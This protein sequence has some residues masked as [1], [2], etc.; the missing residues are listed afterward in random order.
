MCLAASAH[1]VELHKHWSSTQCL[2]TYL[3]PDGITMHVVV[4]LHGTVVDGGYRGRTNGNYGTD[5]YHEWNITVSGGTVAQPAPVNLFDVQNFAVPGP[6]SWS[7]VPEGAPASF[8]GIQ[9]MTTPTDVS[10]GNPVDVCDDVAGQNFDETVYWDIYGPD[11]LFEV[12]YTKP[13]DKKLGGD[14]CQGSPPMALY[15]AHAE[16][17]SLNIQDTPFRYA[18]GRGPSINFTVT[19]NQRDGQPA[20]FT[21]SNLGPKWAFNWLS[22][23]TD[24]PNDD[25]AN[26]TTYVPGG[27]TEVYSG[28]N[29]MTQSYSPDPQSH[30]VLVRTSSSSYEK[31]FPDGSKQIFSVTDGAATYPRKIF[32]TQFIDPAGNAATIGYDGSF[33]VT[34]ITDALGYVTN[35]SYDLPDD[36]LKITKV[37]EP[38]AFGLNRSA[39]FSYTNGQLTTITDEIGIQSVFAYDP[40]SDFIN[41]LTTPY[42]T[43][44][45][46]TGENGTNRWVEMTDPLGAT[47]RVEYRDNAPGISDSDPAGTVPTGFT[48]SGLATG[49]TFYWDKKAYAYYPD[50]TKARITHWALNSDGSPSGI[51]ASEKAPLENRIWYAYE[52]QSDTNHAGPS[53]SPN[54]VARILDDG[55]TQLRQYEYNAIG[56]VTKA[57]DPIGRVTSYQYDANN[58]DLLAVY[59]ER[60]GG[61]SVDPFNAA[62]DL[63]ASYANYY[64]HKPQAVTD[65]A[66]QT[67]NYVY[68]SYG[69][70]QSV[71]NPRNE[72]T[73][74]GY[75]D[76]SS[77]HPSG[78]LTSITSPT[79]NSTSAVTT[80]DYDTAN[81]VR[82]VTS[83]PDGYATVSDYDNLDRPVQIAYPD[84][85]TRQF[86]Y[87]QDFGSGLKTILDLTASKDRDGRWTYRH[88]NGNRQMDSITDPLGQTTYYDWCS[89]GS[90]AG[91]V[92]PN[93]SGVNDLAHKTVFNRDLQSRVTSKVFADGSAIVYTYENTTSRLKSMTDANGQTTNYE[94][95]TD[96]DLAQVSYTNALN[97]TPTVGYAYDPYYNRITSM[98]DGLGTTSYGY[99]PVSTSPTLGAGKL[100]TVDGPFA[101]DTITYG[102]DELG[103]VVSQDINGTAA[104]VVYDSLGRPGTTTNPL[105]SFSRLYENDVTPRL[106][107][108]S[109][110]NGQ[111]TTYNY[112]DNANDRRL[113]ELQNLAADSSNLSQFDY[114]YDPEGQILTLHKNLGTQA[115]TLIFT[116]D[117]AMR[118]TNAGNG[119]TDYI[120]SYDAAGNRTG[121]ESSTGSGT[122]GV[123]YIANN[124]NQLDSFTFDRGSGPFPITYDADGNMTYDG[125]NETFEWDAA[126]RL[127][128]IN[129]LDSG[130]RTEFAYDGLGRRVKIT[131][132]SGIT[133]AKIQPAGSSYTTFRSAQFTL[134]AGGYTVKFQGINPNG[135]DNTALVD[136]V[137]LSGVLIPNGS[138]EAPD[139]SGAPGGY[140]VDP[141]DAN[142]SYEGSAGVAAN[143]SDFTNSNPDAPDGN[144]VAFIQKTGS[145]WQTWSISAGT[146]TL[147]IKAAQRGSGNDTYQQVRIS[148]WASGSPA[149]TKTFVWSG[150]T[151]AEERDATGANVTKRY[152]AEGDQR[153][154]GADAGNYYYTRDHLGSIREV[155]DANGNLVAQMAYDVWG[156]ESVIQGNMNVDFGFTGHYFHQA[157]GLNLAMYREYSPTLGRWINRDPIAEKGGP[158]LYAY[159]N[160]EPINRFDPLGLEG[161]FS[162]SFHE[163]SSGSDVTI[164]FKCANCT[165]IEL[166]QE[167]MGMVPKTQVPSGYT[168]VFIP[169]PKLQQQDNSHA[170]VVT[171]VDEPGSWYQRPVPGDSAIPRIQNV[172]VRIGGFKP[173]WQQ[174]ETCAFCKDPGHERLLGC[175]IWGQALGYGGG[176][177]R[178]GGGDSLG[179]T[180]SVSGL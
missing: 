56:N 5:F 152:F 65:A 93:G 167:I 30:A 33:R 151:I 92:D 62:A 26:V 31:D 48:N 85:S 106:K 103:R 170:G 96:D 76:G 3:G 15:S 71:A 16:Q 175:T 108:V 107:T 45:F 77:G 12:V 64:L 126:N 122:T 101:N 68:N 99:Y 95:Y 174:F 176:P 139:A 27:G 179:Y 146:Y 18:P 134:P 104:S 22:Y 110:P 171:G 32:M 157:S 13:N 69:Q 55:S 36:P 102:Y 8:D 105:G 2:A 168:P 82:T 160:D 24:D 35:I 74:Y 112:F 164:K 144:Q 84:G 109:Y 40:G 73:T 165:K 132:Y 149:S 42:G 46:A 130:N 117:D 50:Y 161:V 83:N 29:S 43:S 37:S 115:G 129:Y 21:Y 120:F 11:A 87:S 6:V 47:E 91:I 177:I 20:T 7:C 156:N 63:I 124:L 39:T 57:T 173:F 4:R 51:S 23:V 135:G 81:R 41:S 137:A 70:I 169:D 136:K 159:V 178:W 111:T 153:V 166:R 78:Y 114:T 10:V 17:A 125:S 131:E 79:F 94:Y 123:T 89:C 119:T 180:P 98:S 138:F 88:Y 155:T 67:T 9:T 133:A 128:A 163:L 100:K 148:L 113:Q 140:L 58:V 172:P 34:T 86:Q 1:A 80:F 145:L 127:L 90:L 154:G 52:G 141:A 142:W 28:F 54:Q 75:G 49:D 44:T 53:G 66:G 143:G 97:P 150:N 38:A 158:N 61:A 14:Q 60:P 162:I 121:N 116:Y 59:Q 118:L 19:Y 147:S 25:S 72:T